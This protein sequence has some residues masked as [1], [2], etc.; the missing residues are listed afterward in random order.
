MDSSRPRFLY[1][2]FLKHIL[3]SLNH[4]VSTSL[5]LC[6]LLFLT[7]VAF[8]PKLQ[9]DRQWIRDWHEPRQAPAFVNFSYD[10]NRFHLQVIWRLWSSSHYLIQSLDAAIATCGATQ[11]LAQ[12]FQCSWHVTAFPQ[13]FVYGFVYGFHLFSSANSSLSLSDLSV[14]L[15]ID[16]TTPVCALCKYHIIQSGSN[17]K[18]QQTA[19]QTLSNST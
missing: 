2:A 15:S 13:R 12:R 7:V 1:P 8:R 6:S 19:K 3:P 4:N 14:R 17:A 5:K 9:I 18:V 11:L 10:F 16:H